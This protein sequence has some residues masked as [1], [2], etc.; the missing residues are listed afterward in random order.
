M[1]WSI[2]LNEFKSS[3]CGGSNL[4]TDCVKVKY[5]KSKA[6]DK[7]ICQCSDLSKFREVF[8]YKEKQNVF[9]YHEMKKKM[10]IEIHVEN[11]FVH[12]LCTG[13]D[14]SP[15]LKIWLGNS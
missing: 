1:Y 12:Q 3:N 2:D 14:K 9:D 10:K 15:D 5:Q 13:V 11:V 6:N 8:D 4:Q 7:P